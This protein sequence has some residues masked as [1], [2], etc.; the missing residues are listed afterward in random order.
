MM[1]QIRFIASLFVG[2][3]IA[4][5]KLLT[6][7]IRA[8]SIEFTTI[9]ILA[10]H[11]VPDIV[12]QFNGGIGDE[13]LLTTVAFEL[14]KRSPKI[15]I[16]QISHSHELL[17][18]NPAYHKIFSWENWQLRYSQLLRFKT[19]RLAYAKEI[20]PKELEAPVSSHIL[21]ILCTKAGVTGEISLR[22]YLYLSEDEKLAC[23]QNHK[24]ITVYCLGE[25]SHISVMKNKIWG[26]ERLQKVIDALSEKYGSEIEILQ[27]GGKDDPRLNNVTDMRGKTT[28]RESAAILSQSICCLTTVGLVMH[29]ARAVHCP[30]VVVYGG[31]EHSWQ[32]GYS[33]NVNIESF[34]ECAPCWKWNECDFE[35]KCMTTI[36]V[37]TV[38]Q[39]IER[40]I[41][42]PQNEL[43]IDTAVV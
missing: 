35:R 20:V 12:L 18:H 33:G 43:R 25:H 3:K 27:I 37:E 23:R 41:N 10:K 38:L 11:G 34:P 26:A 30:S 19:L 24:T 40:L 13:L 22:P 42:H 39:G 17:Q 36:S 28:L 15:K 4:E 32:S 21:S 2:K 8:L 7:L 31:R 14:K 5:M 1:V 16:W 6:K 9:S 29:M